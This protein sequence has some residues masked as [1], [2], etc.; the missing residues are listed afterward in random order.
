M[1]LQAESETCKVHSCCIQKT[2]PHRLLLLTSYHHCITTMSTYASS[3]STVSSLP[4]VSL[5]PSG[6]SSSTSTRSNTGWDV[7]RSGSGGSPDVH[8]H[9][10][11]PFDQMEPTADSPVTPQPILSIDVPI[12][13][14]CLC[15]GSLKEHHRDVLH[16][17]LYAPQ[18]HCALEFHLKPSSPLWSITC[19]YFQNQHL[20]TILN[21]ASSPSSIG[22]RCNTLRTIQ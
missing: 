17:L 5:L 13:A 15:K 1:D 2:S 19:I 11:P 10:T 3:I 4:M 9:P 6:C 7:S 20:K 18:L 8:H 14:H 12:T 22:R 21:L 16:S